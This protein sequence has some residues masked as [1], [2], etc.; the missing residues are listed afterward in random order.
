[1]LME[2][3]PPPPTIQ[4]DLIFFSVQSLAELFFLPVVIISLFIETI[5]VGV[6]V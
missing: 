2:L 3:T 1:M 5:H 6:G 4:M